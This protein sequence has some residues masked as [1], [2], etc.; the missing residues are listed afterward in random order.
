LVESLATIL[1]M[2]QEDLKSL[3]TVKQIRYVKFLTKLNLTTKDKI[4][5]RIENEKNAI[6]K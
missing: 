1:D 2:K 5:T 3:L 4:D 6:K